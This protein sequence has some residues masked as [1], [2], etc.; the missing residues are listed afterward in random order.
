MKEFYFRLH[1][2]NIYIFF[3]RTQDSV[4]CELT[5]EEVRWFYKSEADKRWNE[6][7]GYDSHQIEFLYRQYNQEWLE[8]QAYSDQHAN[9]TAAETLGVKIPKHQIVVRGGMY[10]VDIHNWKGYSIFWPGIIFL[11]HKL[12]FKYIYIFHRGRVSSDERVLV[13]CG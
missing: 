4:I 12:F 13:F 10:E 8:L 2:I 7:N 6:F 5:P 3:W 1:V 11:V 9:G